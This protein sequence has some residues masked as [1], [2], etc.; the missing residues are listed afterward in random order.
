MAVAIA[1]TLVA[2]LP[3]YADMTQKF[4]YENL[5]IVAPK[6]LAAAGI[7]AYVPQMENAAIIRQNC[8]EFMDQLQF[9]WLTA[10]ADKEHIE[11]MRESMAT[12]K[13]R[14]KEWVATFEKDDYMDEWG[15]FV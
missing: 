3:S 12:F 8:K 13:E 15:L 14:F 9:T 10:M 6:L 5:M 1:E 2:E 11:T 4:M 7:R